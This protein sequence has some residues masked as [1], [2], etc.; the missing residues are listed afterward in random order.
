MSNIEN[1]SWNIDPDILGASRTCLENM[2][3]GL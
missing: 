1:L 2:L 3:Q